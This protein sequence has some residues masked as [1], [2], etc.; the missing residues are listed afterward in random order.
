MLAALEPRFW[1]FSK[2]ATYN[3]LAAHSGVDIIR[4]RAENIRVLLHANLTQI[5]LAVDGQQFE[6]ANIASLSGKRARIRSKTLVLCCGG[7]ENA[8]LLLASNIG[9]DLVGRFLMD[10]TDCAIGHFEVHE[11]DAVRSR[12]LVITGWM[13][14]RDGT[15]ICMES[16]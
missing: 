2:S 7:I 4:L 10:H 1:Q 16:A 8:R 9:G 15:L 14:T 6:S 12:V 3:G 5:N 11:A 13:T